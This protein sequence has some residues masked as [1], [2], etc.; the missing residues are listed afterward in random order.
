MKSEYGLEVEKYQRKWLKDDMSLL[1]CDMV[2]GREL[3]AEYFENVNSRNL[4]EDDG[5]GELTYLFGNSCVTGEWLQ[6]DI[7]PTIAH[8]IKQLVKN[9]TFCLS[10]VDN[11]VFLFVTEDIYIVGSQHKQLVM[12][13][14]LMHN[15]H[16][17]EQF[18]HLEYFVT[19]QNKLLKAVLWH[20]GNRLLETDGYVIVENELGINCN[21]IFIWADLLRNKNQYQICLRK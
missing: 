13:A 10:R 8:Q 19:F 6:Q 7:T 15:K 11:D 3:Y 16:E 21:Q 2:T 20:L 17:H 5:I 18:Y 4:Q 9:F 14:Q 12:A 1:P